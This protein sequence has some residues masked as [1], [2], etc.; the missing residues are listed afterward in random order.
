MTAGR[1]ADV[2]SF[3]P[4]HGERPLFVL[5][6]RSLAKASSHPNL[7]GSRVQPGPG[8]GGRRAARTGRVRR[9]GEG[10]SGVS[11]QRHVAGS[12]SGPGRSEGQQRDPS[13]PPA[14]RGSSAG[15]TRGVTQPGHAPSCVFAPPLGSCNAFRLTRWPP[16]SPLLCV[17]PCNDLCRFVRYRSPA[18]SR[19]LGVDSAR[20]MSYPAALLRPTQFRG[21]GGGG[22]PKI[23]CA[24]TA[25]AHPPRPDR[26]VPARRRPLPDRQHRLQRRPF[27]RLSP[28]R[29]RR[30]AR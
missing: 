1:G 4:E 13:A 30:S 3:F 12:Q 5:S 19:P 28:C 2:T 6:L 11:R 26:V 23:S 16:Q 8:S 7:G 14:V 10:S 24:P 29:A 21:G 25:P 15:S 22:P 17:S 27:R 20:K 18:A 9:W